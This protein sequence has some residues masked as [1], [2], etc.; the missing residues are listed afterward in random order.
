MLNGME[1]HVNCVGLLREMPLGKLASGFEC[2]PAGTS[3]MHCI[4][5]QRLHQHKHNHLQ[6]IYITTVTISRMYMQKHHLYTSYIAG[7]QS[8]SCILMFKYYIPIYIHTYIILCRSYYWSNR[9]V[10][11]SGEASLQLLACQHD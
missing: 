3:L 4:W 10:L 6:S 5:Q 2:Y 7:I 1:Y 11:D 8:A 9:F